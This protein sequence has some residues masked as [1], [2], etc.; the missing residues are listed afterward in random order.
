[1]ETLRKYPRTVHLPFSRSVTSD[2]VQAKDLEA[3]VKQWP[4]FSDPQTEMV[5]TEKMDGENTTLYR[6]A[7][8]A[9]SMDSRDHPSRSF[10]KGVWGGVRWGI[11]EGRRIVCENVYAQHSVRYDSLETFVFAFAVIDCLNEA[12]ELDPAGVPTFRDWDTSEQVMAELGLTPVPVLYRGPAS[13]E[14][15]QEV[16]LGLDHERQ[17]GVVVRNAAAFSEAD[18]Q[19]NVGK[20]VRKDHVQTDEHWTRRWVPNA[21]AK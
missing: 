18:F 12:G 5:I 2:D 21:L 11:P 16:F 3:A 9:R 8:H 6:N 20:A 17:E 7:I 19:K 10:V 4:L 14:K 1:M 15:V 13:L